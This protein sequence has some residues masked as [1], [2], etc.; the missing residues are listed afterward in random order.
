MDWPKAKKEQK[1]L[2]TTPKSE[3]VI[4]AE[5]LPKLS[6]LVLGEALFPAQEIWKSAMLHLASS[7]IVLHASASAAPPSDGLT[8]GWDCISC[9]TNSMLI[10]NVGTWNRRN[11]DLKDP[12][13]INT[14]ADSHAAVFLN[15]FWDTSY[16]GTGDD[17]KIKVARALKARNPKVFV[18]LP[19]Q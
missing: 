19:T 17:N 18:P 3:Q 11:F 16:N 13:W 2:I 14:L 10:S 9:K 6:L 4:A 12:W 8:H 15:T 7:F 5:A 1:Q